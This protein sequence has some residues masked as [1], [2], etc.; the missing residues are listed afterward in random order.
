MYIYT[1]VLNNVG[2][3]T[4]TN[5]QLTLRNRKKFKTTTTNIEKHQK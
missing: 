1:E 3:I 4:I 5:T 2:T